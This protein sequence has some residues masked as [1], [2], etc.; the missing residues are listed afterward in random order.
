MMSA[1]YDGTHLAI[2]AG[3]CEPFN[4]FS[5]QALTDK[6]MAELMF[7]YSDKARAIENYVSSRIASAFRGEVGTTAVLLE[8]RDL[9]LEIGDDSPL[10]DYFLLACAK[11]DLD[12]SGMQWYWNGATTDNI[13]GIIE[14]YFTSW[15][16]THCGGT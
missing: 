5:L 7:D 16:S 15:M 11:E 12:A 2:L 8:L 9:H 10:E 4:Q 14:V 3:E 13:D 1:G 6:V